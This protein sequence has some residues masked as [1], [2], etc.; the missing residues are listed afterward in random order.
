[1]TQI[2]AIYCPP[3]H[4]PTL[5]ERHSIPEQMFNAVQVWVQRRALARLSDAHLCDIGLSRKQANREAKRPI[6]DVPANWRR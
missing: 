5:K 4:A 1:M 2:D 3:H 6:W